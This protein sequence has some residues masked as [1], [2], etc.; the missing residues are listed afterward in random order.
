MF[1]SALQPITPT[2]TLTTRL[3]VRGWEL[4]Q[5]R[6]LTSGC[7][8]WSGA[9]LKNQPCLWVQSSIENLA[10]YIKDFLGK[11]P[12]AQSHGNQC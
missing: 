10:L 9:L 11:T 12:K 7:L 4:F 2:V 6:G 5:K 8:N 3:S 1:L